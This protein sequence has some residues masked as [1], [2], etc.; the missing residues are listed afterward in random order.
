MKNDIEK[1]MYDA[2]FILVIKD[3]EVVVLKNRN[4]LTRIDLINKLEELK[5][6]Q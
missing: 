5:V 2:E 6:G 1:L 4:R 3:G